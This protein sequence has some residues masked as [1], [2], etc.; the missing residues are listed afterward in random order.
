[1]ATEP[2]AFQSVYNEGPYCGLPSYPGITGKTAI[3]VGANGISGQYMLRLLAK[4][5]ERWTKIYALSR[6]PPQG[7][8]SPQIKHVSVDLLAGVDSI[9]QV[10]ETENVS[11]DYVFFF[12]YKESPSDDGKLW[13]GQEQM[14]IDNSKMLRDLILAL[15]ERPFKRL[16]LQTGAKHYGIH[17]GPT[18]LPCKEDDPLVLTIPNFYYQQEDILKELGPKQNFDWSVVRPSHIVGAVKGNFM[19]IAI[20]VGLYIVI[21]RELGDPVSFYG[22]R[23]KYLGV[24]TFSSAYLNST[25]SEYCALTPSCSNQAFNAANGDMPTW[26][27]LLPTVATYFSAPMADDSVLDQPGFSPFKQVSN[28]PAP[29]NPNEHGIF[30]L[31]TSLAEWAKQD[32]VKAAWDQLAERQG[33]DKEVFSSA[34]WAFADG[35]ASFQHELMLDMN[36]ARIFG[37]HGTVDSTADFLEVLKTAQELNFLPKTS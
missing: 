6:R 11:G 26:S 27:R 7:F 9:Q 24:E 28:L 12:A 21:S 37:F 29:R 35:V 32:R 1:M 3:V 15:R 33:L 18:V 23:S 25:L 34:S 30:E 22:T 2:P 10:L 5:P 8:N 14:V 36:K 13:G 16:V 17:I 19:N 31:R 20:A 4:Y